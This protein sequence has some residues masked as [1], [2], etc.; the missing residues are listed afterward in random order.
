MKKIYTTLLAAILV[1]GLNAQTL[2]Q[3]NNAPIIGDAYGTRQCD[4]TTISPG[5]NG[6]GATWNYSTIAVRTPTLNYAGVSAAS[7][8][9]AASYP[10]AAVAVGQG[11]NKYSFYSSTAT[12]LSYWGGNVIIGGQNAVL[13]YTS[14]SCMA[15]YPMSLGSSTTSTVGGSLTILGNNGTFTGTVTANAS[16]SGTLM[17]PSATFNNVLKVVTT[18]NFNATI[19]LGSATISMIRYDYYSA[20]AKYPMF[21]ISTSTVVSLAGTNTE[22]IVTVNTAF[23]LGVKEIQNSVANLN[24]YPNPAKGNLTVSFTNANGENASYEMIN[25]IGQTVKKEIL[26]NEKGQVNQN[27]S[28]EGIESGIY[29]IKVYVGNGTS[30]KKV[31]VQ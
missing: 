12:S 7:T 14:P 23:S 19:P 6:A 4:S 18:Q 13:S 26:S 29:F 30:V 25:A 3:A 16:G 8:G 24:F 20:A 9:S 11:A 31:T 5:A 15:N 27:I 22:T 28:L 17:L 21:T 10:S 2:T 1:S